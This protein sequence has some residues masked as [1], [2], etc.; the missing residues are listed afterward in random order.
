[1][2]LG[3][4]GPS[5]SSGSGPRPASRGAGGRRRA[6]KQQGLLPGTPAARVSRKVPRGDLTPRTNASRWA[7]AG[8]PRSPAGEVW[9]TRSSRGPAG[10]TRRRDSGRGAA[11]SVPERSCGG[12]VLRKHGGQVKPRGQAV[13]ASR[14]WFR[15]N[16]C[17]QTP[18]RL[19]CQSVFSV[20]TPL[21]RGGAGHS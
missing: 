21:A 13:P 15:F 11:G 20:N 3:W 16:E 17:R 6:N 1:M 10:R 12:S 8:R 7:I 19:G 2:G 14:G 4:A 9:F 18:E 5:R